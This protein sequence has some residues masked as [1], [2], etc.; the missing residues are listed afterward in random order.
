MGD[1]LGARRVCAPSLSGSVRV[2][3][4]R[5][6]HWGRLEGDEVVVDDGR[7]ILEAE[8]AYL[9]PVEPSKIIAVHL[10]YRSRIE[11]YRRADPGCALVL[12]EAAVDAERPPRPRSCG[13][14]GRAT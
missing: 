1:R 9:A 13:R 4:G 2:E 5:E 8:A 7:R 14:P 11:E 12:P 10:S 3:L 6:P